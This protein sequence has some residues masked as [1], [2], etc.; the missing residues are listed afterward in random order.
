M[1]E[2]GRIVERGS[3]EELLARAGRYAELHAT[4]FAAGRKD[5]AAARLD[6]A[7]RPK[8][9]AGP[10]SSASLERGGTGRG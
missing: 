4:Q 2:A 6:D 7:T 5:D 8:E 1:I 3:H 9:G 10:A